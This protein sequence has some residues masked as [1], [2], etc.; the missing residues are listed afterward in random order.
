MN[1]R[2][3]D[4]I[5]F[6]SKHSQQCRSCGKR[7]SLIEKITYLCTKCKNYFCEECAS[8]LNQNTTNKKDNCPGG[9][10]QQHEAIIAKITR[11]VK[12]YAPIGVSIDVLEKQKSLQSSA[13]TVKILDSD[14]SKKK[15]KSGVKILDN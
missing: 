7:I 1:N 12:E 15:K 5:H 14:E 6:Q 2:D 3:I 10:H 11:T 13:S 9:D 4:I 8:F